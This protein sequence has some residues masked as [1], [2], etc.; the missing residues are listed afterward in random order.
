MWHQAIT[1]KSIIIMRRLLLIA[2]LLFLG[3]VMSAGYS[4]VAEERVT[5]FIAT[6]GYDDL[7]TDGSD[8]RDSKAYGADDG[9]R[10]D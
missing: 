2:H 7:L 9:T 4:R 10:P 5:G 6:E 1:D 8:H 3:I